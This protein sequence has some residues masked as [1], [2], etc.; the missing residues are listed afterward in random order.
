MTYIA[1]QGH[2]SRDTTEPDD[3][4]AGNGTEE[5][6]RN[7]KHHHDVDVAR[8]DD[9]LAHSK[10][11]IV[12]GVG[13][14]L[15]QEFANVNVLFSFEQLPAVLI[16][17]HCLLMLLPSGRNRIVPVRVLPCPGDARTFDGLQYWTLPRRRP[18]TAR[19]RLQL[20]LR[21]GVGWFDCE[22]TR[23]GLSARQAADGTMNVGEIFAE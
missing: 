12:G 11:F 1:A 9:G 13:G 19:A 16:S 23:P 18:R 15:D 22:V 20:T 7:G 3:P 2:V 10:V 4:G 8:R 6:E 17:N 14:R 5:P 21:L